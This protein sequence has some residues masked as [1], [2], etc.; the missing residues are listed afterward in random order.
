MIF[1]YRKIFNFSEKR[2]LEIKAGE[3]RAK[4]REMLLR[5]I[6]CHFR[7]RMSPYLGSDVARFPVPDDKVSWDVCTCISYH[8]F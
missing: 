4:V 6:N 3:E 1:T 7:S 5:G 8:V 2:R